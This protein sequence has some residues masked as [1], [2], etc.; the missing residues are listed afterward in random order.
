MRH[1]GGMTDDQIGAALGITGRT[2]SRDWEEARPPLAAA[3]RD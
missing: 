1:F 2:V 3:Q